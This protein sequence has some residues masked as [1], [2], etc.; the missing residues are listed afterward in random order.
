M[1]LPCIKTLFGQPNKLNLTMQTP[2]KA[3][4][5]QG[6]FIAI[7]I[8]TYIYVCIYIYIYITTAQLEY[9]IAFDYYRFTL[10]VELRVKCWEARIQIFYSCTKKYAKRISY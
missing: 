4:V 8:Y 9:F 7:Y 3:S 1:V 6:A 2:Q 5:L 10:N